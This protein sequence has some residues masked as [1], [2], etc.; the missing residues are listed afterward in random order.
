MQQWREVGNALLV[1]LISILLMAGALSISLVE[2]VPESTP[3]AANPVPPSPL[4]LT[5]TATLPSTATPLLLESPTPSI[6][7]TTTI[8]ATSPSSCPIPGGWGQ[9]VVRIGDTLDDIAIRYRVDKNKLKNANCLISESLVAGTILYVP[10]VATNT[11]VI[12]NQGAVAWVHTY[13]VQAGDT[14]Y[15]IALNHSTSVG[16][17]KSVNCRASDLIYAGEV[18]WV[19]NVP[20]RTPYPTPE[21]GKTVTPIPTEPLT[22]TAMPFTVTPV[23]SSTPEPATPT[24]IPTDTLEPTLTASPTAFQ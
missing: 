22:E 23:P 4:P 7:P 21:P 10:P 2:F 24:P 6:T 14:I 11:P 9:T 1:A 20:T 5:V 19:P 18:L 8:T 13:T 3:T 15:S 12:C 16:L 17:L